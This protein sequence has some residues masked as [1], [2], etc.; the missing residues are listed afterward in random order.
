[1]AY[2]KISG[3]SDEICSDF[4]E[5]LENVKKLGMS[6]I[7]IRGLNGRNIAEYSLD[8][9]E[10]YILPVMN[11]Y[12][13]K[14]SSIGSPIGKIFIDDEK[15]FNKQC[16]QLE[17]LVDACCLMECKYIRMFSFYIP[18]GENVD[19]YKEEVIRKLKVFVEI[20]AK[21]N[22]I[23]LHENEKDIFGDT[24]IRCKQL[25]DEIDSKNLKLI[26]DFAN[27]VQ[28]GVDTL[29][30]FDLL[31]D[32]IEYIHIKDAIKKGNQNVL[33][34]T[35]DGKIPEILK[36]V[37]DN[38]Y[39][40]FLTLEPHLAVFEFLQDLELEDVTEIIKEDLCSSGQEA[41]EVQYNALCGILSKI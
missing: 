32:D 41:Y 10:Q 28:V 20:A 37:F 24:D 3:F 12:G 26:F 7:S 29:Q 9:V 4:I 38:G 13:I 17:K 25:V 18:K 40:G 36:M 14:V 5:Q 15:S 19:K 33:C 16:E 31:K 21:K 30:A 8:E 27:F 34:G 1:M 2:K 23:L 35:G 6:Y 39:N 11:K 22:I